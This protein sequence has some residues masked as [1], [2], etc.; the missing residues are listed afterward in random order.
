MA[1][2]DFDSDSAPF[3]GSVLPTIEDVA[4]LSEDEGKYEVFPKKRSEEPKADKVQLFL[5]PAVIFVGGLVLAFF[6]VA[7]LS[8]KIPSLNMD[9]QNIP[10]DQARDI[11]VV[12]NSPRKA[13]LEF[14]QSL[15]Q[16]GKKVVF[17]HGK[18]HPP[19]KVG[20][21]TEGIDFYPVPDGAL[22]EDGVLLD[23]YKWYPLSP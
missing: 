17:F 7:G 9:L 3:T 11:R 19:G 5:L 4:M 8:D 15:V 12:E 22:G 2:I 16:Q 18:S 1:K 21:G 10:L 14:A 23:G 13:S 20:V 6:Y